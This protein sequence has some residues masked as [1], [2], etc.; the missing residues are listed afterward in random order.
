MWRRDR[1]ARDAAA[2]PGQVVPSEIVGEDDD[3]VRRPFSGW[4]SEWIGTALPLDGHGRSDVH[5][6]ACIDLDEGEKDFEAEDPGQSRDEQQTGEPA[7]EE[8]LVHRACFP[9]LGVRCLAVD[10]DTGP[11]RT[12]AMA[13][14]TVS[15]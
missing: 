1:T 7:Q 9:A 5:L 6:P 15:K 2:E 8:A 10:S 14:S 12:A 13:S 11:D 3:D 4:T